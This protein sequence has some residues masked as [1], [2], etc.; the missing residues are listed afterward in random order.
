MLI[1]VIYATYS[2]FMKNL[3]INFLQVRNSK[4]YVI[5]PQLGI[6]FHYRSRLGKKLYIYISNVL[7]IYYIY[8]NII[9][10]RERERM[11]KNESLL[12]VHP[13]YKIL[14]LAK[15]CISHFFKSV[16]C[17][18]RHLGPKIWGLLLKKGEK[19]VPFYQFKPKSESAADLKFPSNSDDISTQFPKFS[20]FPILIIG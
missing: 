1:S 18:T 4:I 3:M 8:L 11:I 17:K 16:T 7:H 5:K 20:T 13:N 14:Q 12:I 6:H 10:L 19:V 2:K 9:V 15:Y